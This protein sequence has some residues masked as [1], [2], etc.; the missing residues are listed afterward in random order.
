MARI[1]PVSARKA[2]WL[3]RFANWYSR[4]KLGADPAPLGIIGHH[5]RLLVGMSAMEG[6]LE[7]SRCVSPSLKELAQIKVAALVGCPF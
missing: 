7:R 3:L 4:R 5:T 6:A 1:Q 2:S